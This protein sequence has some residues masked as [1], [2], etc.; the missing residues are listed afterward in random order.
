MNQLPEVKIDHVR[1]KAGGPDGTGLTADEIVSILEAAGA[2]CTRADYTEATANTREPPPFQKYLYGSIESGYPVII[3]FGT[4]N[5]DHHAIPLFGHT[6]NE[7]T[8]VP[9]AEI[10]YFRVGAGTA[11]VPSE[12]WLSTYLGHDDNWGSNFC[13]P[14][15]FLYT[16]RRCKDRPA[17]APLCNMQDECVAHVI[18]T[19]PK[20]VKIN[21]LRAEVIGSDF[22]FSML[23]QLPHPGKSWESRLEVSAKANRLVLRAILIDSQDYVKH[24]AK[25]SDW[26]GCLFSRNEIQALSAL[27]KEKLWMIELSVPELFS[28]NRRKVGEVLIRAEMPPSNTRDFSTFVLGRLPGYFAIYTGGG[29]SNPLYQFI[30]NGVSGHVELFGCEDAGGRPC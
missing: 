3:C 21:G 23:P 4:S 17:H 7:D 24:L 10:S 2:N 29:S 18:S 19:L 9:S 25:V 16:R 15:N 27:S 30:P 14:R 8:W 20:S 28:A 22:L 6:F 26:A 13:V 11:Y 5:Q 12:S 1:K